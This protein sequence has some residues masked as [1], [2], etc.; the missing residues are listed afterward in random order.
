LLRWGDEGTLQGLTVHTDK[1][2]SLDYYATESNHS[3]VYC[4]INLLCWFLA[5]STDLDDINHTIKRTEAF[6]QLLLELRGLLI[7]QN[8]SS[9]CKRKLFMVTTGLFSS[10]T[11][12]PLT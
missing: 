9:L 6:L 5:K 11:K 1:R 4:R 8:K 7:N 3:G 2:L 12:D 10:G